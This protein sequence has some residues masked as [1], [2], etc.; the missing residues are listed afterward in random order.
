VGKALPP[1]LL[2][3]SPWSRWV[4]RQV[5]GRHT[6]PPSLPRGAAAFLFPVAQLAPAC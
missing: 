1:S 2:A 4:V 6:G 5:R 3:L